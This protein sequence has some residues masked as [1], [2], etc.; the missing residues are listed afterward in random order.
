MANSYTG[1]LKLAKPDLDDPRWD[2]QWNANA[3]SVDALAAIGGLCVAPAEVPSVTLSVVVSAG[4]FVMLSGLALAY[5]GG[6]LTLPDDATT[7]LWLS[8]GGGLLSGPA[9]PAG[10]C[11]PL[12]VVDTAAGAVLAVADARVVLATVG[13][14]PVYAVRLVSGNTTLADTDY[15]VLVDA[16][17]GPVT[18]T[19]PTAAGRPGRAFCVKKIDASANAVTIAPTSGQVDGAAS[20]VLTAQ[21][22]AAEVV[23]HGANYYVLGGV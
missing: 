18:I 13:A 8:D 1:R 5:A 17:V 10:P 19:I 7:Y 16:T 12:A 4:S 9:W 3:D 11:V 14:P 22:K 21:W 6:T 23:A 2:L 20:K 15:A